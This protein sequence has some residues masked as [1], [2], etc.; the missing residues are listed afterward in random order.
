M[1]S[2]NDKKSERLDP[3]YRPSPSKQKTSAEIISEA[4]SALRAVG[5]QR[6]CTPREDQRR[7][8]GPKSSRTPENRPPSSFSLHASSFEPPDS[9]PI[10]GTR[11][12]PLELKPRAL[13][14][15]T[16]EE[17][18]HLTFPRPPVDPAKMRRISS[19]RARLFRAASQG[20]LLP[21]RS[22]PA[23]D[24]PR[25]AGHV[26]S[27]PLQRTCD[28]GFGETGEPE[29]S[30]G[31]VPS[32]PHPR[33]G[34]YTDMLTWAVF[35][36]TLLRCFNSLNHWEL[37][38][39]TEQ[40]QP[41]VMLRVPGK[42][43]AR[44]PSRP[45]SSDP[46]RLEGRAP[47]PDAD[48]QV[49]DGEAEVDE[50]FWNTRIVPILN[51]LEKEGDT[52]ALCAACTQLHHTLAEGSLLGRRF[53]RRNALL[54][55]LYK[56]VDAGSDLL[57][58][59]LAKIILAL[60]VG[61]RNL[62][63]V[64]KLVFM[65]SRSE[66]N[67]PALHSEHVLESLLEVLRSEDVHNN[68]EAFLYC[69]GTV[70]FLSGNPC[71]LSEVIHQGATETL[72][73][74]LKQM[75]QKAKDRGA[76][77]PTS[78]HLLVQVT[79]TLRNLVD[80]PQA[81]SK[82]LSVSALAELC[83]V[84]EQ[85][86]DD[87]DVCTNISRIFSRL[88]AH[89]D[90][91]TALAGHVPCYALFLTLIHKHQEKQDLVVRIVFILGNLTA[92]SSQARE[93]FFREKGAVP[94]LLALFQAFCHGHVPAPR[95]QPAGAP[96][97]PGPRPSEAEDV[98]IKVTRVLA[99]LAIHPRVGP[100]LAADP[101]VVSL[102]LTTLEHRSLGDCEELVINAAAAVNNLSFYRGEASVVQD[103]RLRIA[104]LLLKLLMSTNMGGVLEAVRVFGNL[105]Q[106]R[107][108]CSFI[109]QNNVHKFMIALLDSRQQDI[110]FSACGVLLNLTVDRDKRIILKEGGG[111]QKLVDCLRDFGPT[112]W[113][114]AS[115]VCKTLWNFSEHIVS[116]SSCFGDEATNTLLG[117]LPIFLDEESAL[118]GSLD[119]DLKNYHR[120]SWETEFR[121]VAQQLLLRIR[122]HLTPMPVPPFQP[123]HP[124]VRFPR[125]FRPGSRTVLGRVACRDPGSWLGLEFS[126]QGGSAHHS[127]PHRG[128]HDFHRLS[129]ISRLLTVSSANCQP[130]QD[131]STEIPKLRLS[132]SH[133]SSPGLRMRQFLSDT[134]AAGSGV[135]TGCT[136][137]A[138][139]LPALSEGRRTTQQPLPAAPD[140]RLPRLV[141]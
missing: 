73:H 107:D 89:R 64:C 59:K 1:L 2:S 130:P 99:N 116:A 8:F 140:R 135:A 80:S 41:V 7:L 141:P 124:E 101:H 20:T 93:H 49:K 53:P 27:H 30:Q 38:L 111:I 39:G 74:L 112:D 106:D 69:V 70:K 132:R 122:S 82:L 131:C 48:L 16:A 115:L 96:E 102:L 81:R 90:G 84:A 88:T 21:D 91:C 79:A 75:N 128:L 5:T 110:C 12:S 24:G 86:V 113:Q 121:P 46:G 125:T 18:A 85:H 19:A 26:K 45:G 71:F 22:L 129:G 61:R 65:I 43:H 36:L 67:D 6:P 138:P 37:E 117:L 58:L 15:P 42:R 103:R 126:L 78:G 57:S 72:M 33:S 127:R 3:F 14:S 23:T 31:P 95:R 47:V 136:G 94:T 25:A 4:R 83:T 109:V 139:Q 76:C 77:L 11:L 55:A 40:S 54:R 34:G 120:L 44:A 114:L 17:D 100:T 51:E 10:S 105:S 92:K 63:N 13:A 29:A 98:L 32:P 118:G 134:K 108:I 133:P 60:R 66:R 97:A 68:M 104:E 87:K 62:L 52:E 56:L 123:Q 28:G 9:R 35:V 119:Q 50:A 137:T